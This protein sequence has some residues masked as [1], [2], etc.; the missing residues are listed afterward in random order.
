MSIINAWKPEED[1]VLHQALGK[2]AEECSELAKIAM[3]CMIQGY[4][5][6]DPVTQKLNSTA[7]MEEAADVR[8]TMRWL[9][10]VLDKPFKGESPREARKF[11]GFKRWEAMLRASTPQKRLS[12]E[13]VIL[14]SSPSAELEG[15]ALERHLKSLI[16]ARP[17]KAALA[18]FDKDTRLWFVAQLASVASR[19]VPLT[20]IE[21]VV[22]RH[23]PP[24]TD[25]AHAN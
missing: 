10:D 23:L 11:D 1:V 17:N 18:A 22:A 9:F 21:G 15:D 25:D 8:A 13:E 20:D 3:R 16:V 19:R 7:L 2:L 24:A 12:V 5:E 14:R 6:A 4:A